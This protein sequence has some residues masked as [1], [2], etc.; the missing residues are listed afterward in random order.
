[1][2]FCAETSLGHVQMSFTTLIRVVLSERDISCVFALIMRS[3]L[4][5]AP[6]WMGYMTILSLDI[7]SSDN[8]D[9]WLSQGVL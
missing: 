6:D 7:L 8:D 3:Q 5:S 1:M 9:R 4:I 2:V